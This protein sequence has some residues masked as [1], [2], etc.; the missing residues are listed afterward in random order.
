MRITGGIYKNRKLAVPTGNDIRPTPE[1]MRQTLFN[2]LRHAA[3]ADNWYIEGSSVIDLFCGSG[4]LGLEALSQGAGY[5]LF[6]DKDT[7]T[8]TQNSHFLP[9]AHFE[10]RQ[11]DA[12]RINITGCYDLVFIDPPY[13]NNLVEPAIENLIACRCLNDAAIIVVETEKSCGLKLPLEKLD[14]RIQSQSE[15]HIFRYDTAIE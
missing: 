3:W 12:T 15:L 1:R 5:C 9:K 2:L 11:E 13:N 10:I 8:V 14:Q 6:I 7:K 4:A